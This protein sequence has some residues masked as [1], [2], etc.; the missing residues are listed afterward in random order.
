M[1]FN[2][3]NYTQIP[4]EIFDYWMEKLTPAEFKVLLCI[5]RKTFGWQKRYDCISLKQITS[6]TGLSKMGII[7]NID[8]LMELGLIT[9]IK[10]KSSDGDDAPNVYE[11]NVNSVGGGSKPS[12]LG[13]V[14][15]VDT[16][17]V[18]S[19]DTQKKD[20]TKERHTKEKE[21]TR[22]PEGAQTYGENGLVKLQLKEFEDLLK[23]MSESER[24]ER[25]IDLEL[26]IL[27]TGEPEFNRKYKSHYATIL[28]WKRLDD[29]KKE[30][31]WKKNKYQTTSSDC[32]PT[33]SDSVTLEQWSQQLVCLG[34]IL[35][36]STDG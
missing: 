5:C 7:K 14:N 15:S 4:N 1:G 16:P 2:P 25:L 19:V 6:L 22:A 36:S 31:S 32:K 13:V 10:S 12:L 3:P 28:S 26:A 9:K 20:P 17:V 23:H 33:S 11:I 30:P 8:R 18:N 29:K 35:N 27:K 21:N 34:T 24:K